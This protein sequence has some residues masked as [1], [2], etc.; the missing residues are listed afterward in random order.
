VLRDA[1]PLRTALIGKATARARVGDAEWAELIEQFRNGPPVGSLFRLPG[2]DGVANLEE[3]F[4]HHE[5]VRRAT[6]GWV[7]RELPPGIEDVIWRRVRTPLAKLAVRR[8]DVGVHIQRPNGDHA[9]LRAAR[10]GVVVTGPPSELL[11]FL[12]GRQRAADVELRGPADAC[13]RLRQA[14]LGV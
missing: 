13:D 12:F 3:F 7:R 10:P 1:G 2:V 4:V 8:V 6:D 5:D 11:F 14:T 9:T